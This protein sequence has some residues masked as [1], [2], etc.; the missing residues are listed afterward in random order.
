MDW[1]LPTF[2]V[3]QLSFSFLIVQQI[4]FAKLFLDQHLII[5]S[6]QINC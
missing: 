5:F 4:L 1:S 2:A 3:L 6:T